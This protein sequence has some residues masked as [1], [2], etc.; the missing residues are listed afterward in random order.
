MKMRKRVVER[1]RV[2]KKMEMMKNKEDWKIMI[3]DGC[4]E[5]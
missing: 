5:R 4:V 1:I 2:R 3:K